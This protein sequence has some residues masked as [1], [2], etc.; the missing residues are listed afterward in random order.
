MIEGVYTFELIKFP[1]DHLDLLHKTRQITLD[2]PEK[3]DSEIT[4]KA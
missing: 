1:A 2:V 4:L 3:S